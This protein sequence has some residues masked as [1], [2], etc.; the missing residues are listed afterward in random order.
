VKRIVFIGAAGS[1]KSALSSQVFA[2]LKT[3]GRQTEHVHEFVRVDIHR[4][5]AMTSIWEQ[6]R[7]RQ[8][9]KELEDVVPAVVDYVICDSG[10]LT[11]FFYATLY[12]N[13][14]DPRERLVLQDMYRYLLD[15][16]VLR[17]YDLVFFLPVM[18]NVKLDDGTRFQTPEEIR[19]LDDHMRLFFTKL[20]PMSN[21]HFIE[22]N[23]D[24]RLEAVMWKILGV[25]AKQILG[26]D[27]LTLISSS[28]TV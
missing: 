20:H 2:A 25:E 6:Y 15:D 21:V 17:R 8:Y 16:L 10:T 3:A 22:C 4:N 19:L 11:P 18:G 14:S 9:Q 13:L 1:G 12:A 24:Q 28:V 5:G 27:K 7:T 26:V 23:F